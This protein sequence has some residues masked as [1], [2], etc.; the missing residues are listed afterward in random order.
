MPILL[1]Y[2]KLFLLQIC[3]HNH[4][5]LLLLWVDPY[6]ILFSSV[7]QIKCNFFWDTIF[8]NMK[9]FFWLITYIHLRAGN[10]P[11][12]YTSFWK[13][14]LDLLE[15]SPLY[16]NL[17][18]HCKIDMKKKLFHWYKTIFKNYF[19]GS[20]LFLMEFENRLLYRLAS[21]ISFNQLQIWHLIP[22]FCYFLIYLI[23]NRLLLKFFPGVPPLPDCVYF[24]YQSKTRFYLLP[25]FSANSTGVCITI[26][27]TI[28]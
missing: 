19:S 12:D 22:I 20:N 4:F 27:I 7:I 23:H 24:V 2:L 16:Y 5:L 10:R 15:E 17:I 8:F 1:C 28:A 21:I 14:Y 3:V 18:S 25:F 26:T 6:S 13:L 9:I 11:N